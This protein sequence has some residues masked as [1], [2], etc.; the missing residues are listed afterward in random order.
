MEQ[1][2]LGKKTESYCQ[3]LSG[4]SKQISRW[5][6]EIVVVMHLGGLTEKEE[7]QKT[8]LPAYVI[9]IELGHSRAVKQHDMCEKSR[10]PHDG[11]MLLASFLKYK[12]LKCP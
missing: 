9:Y 4:N 7:S 2:Q 5:H 6:G 3:S 10:I 11:E 12:R 1:T 8:K